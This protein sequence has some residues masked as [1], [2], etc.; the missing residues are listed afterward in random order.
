MAVTLSR[1]FPINLS[2]SPC[3]APVGPKLNNSTAEDLLSLSLLHETTSAAKAITMITDRRGL[4][5]SLVIL[6][7]FLVK[8]CY[9]FLG[10]T[11]RLS[12]QISASRLPGPKI[13]ILD[14]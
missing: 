13:K 11:R 7:I 9:G 4:R 8:R 6:N 2:V 1:L 12:K 14:Q 5:N 10:T 3:F